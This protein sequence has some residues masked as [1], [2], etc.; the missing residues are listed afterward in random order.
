[1]SQNEPKSLLAGCSSNGYGSEIT[2]T[3]SFIPDYRPLSA[4]KATSL[5][6]AISY[7]NGTTYASAEFSRDA[8]ETFVG[9]SYGAVAAE[10]P[11]FTNYINSLCY[12]PQ[13]NGRWNIADCSTTP[14]IR[15]LL[16]NSSIFPIRTLSGLSLGTGDGTT[17]DF[18]PELPAW[19]ANSEKVYINGTQ[20]TRGVDYQVDH[21]ANLAKYNSVMLGN[22]AIEIDAERVNGYYAYIWAADAGAPAR[23]GTAGNEAPAVS[24]YRPMIIKYADSYAFSNKVNFYSLGKWRAPGK[25][26]AG[27]SLVF[28]YSRDDAETWVE[29]HRITLAADGGNNETFFADSHM[30][31]RT[32]VFDEHIMTTVSGITHTKIA[33]EDTD[34][35][36]RV[37]F[38]A[39]T[40]QGRFG[41]VG[42]Y[43]IR[44]TNPP[45]AG[46]ALT[47]DCNIDRPWKSNE[48]NIQWNPIINFGF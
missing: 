17:T 2:F 39:P 3:P 5:F 37:F 40:K 34:T 19:L 28:Y 7:N 46:A 9:D 18:A 33:L 27:A 14:A 32:E 25:I 36:L 8:K 29:F 38:W 47:M 10:G 45:A 20:Q 35:D 16:P 6:T 22:F 30:E 31:G 4:C 23:F 43:A 24:I 13:T 44:F 48:N 1:M 41:Y 11:V 15:I 26:L 12:G 21:L 42:E